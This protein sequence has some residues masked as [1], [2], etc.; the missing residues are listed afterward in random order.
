MVLMPMK[1][2]R[3][4]EDVGLGDIVERVIGPLGGKAF[5]EWH[6]KIFGTV[7]GGCDIRKEN[8]NQRFP[9]L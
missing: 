2:L 1:L 5:Q 8:W 3:R 4:K 7:C 6:V 9:L